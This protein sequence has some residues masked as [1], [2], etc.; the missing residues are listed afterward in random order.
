MSITIYHVSGTRSMRVIWLCYELDIPCKVE[1]I[2]FAKK[3]RASPGWRAKSPTGKVPAM[4]DGALTMFE[5]GAMVQYL[6]DRYGKG[7]LQPESGTPAGALYLQWCW[8]AEATFARPLGD[9]AQHTLVREEKDRIQAVVAD[10]Q[11]RSRT[12]LEAIEAAVQDSHY[13]LGRFTAADIMMGYSLMLAEKFGLITEDLPAT[14]AY[15]AR[16]K[17]RQ[18]YQ[19]AV[20]V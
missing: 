10:G 19:Y 1:T 4:D 7:Q 2:D 13:L 11:Q 3:F 17:D 9:I 8:F 20:S 15:F 5:S 18:G 6:L 12:C 14:E 16:L